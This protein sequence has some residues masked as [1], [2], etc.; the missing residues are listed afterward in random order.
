MKE[1]AELDHL[2]ETFDFL[3]DWTDRYR[4]LIE[5]AGKLPPF[6]EEARVAEN[7]V[8]GCMS[9][10]WLTARQDGEDPCVLHFRADSDAQIVKGLIAVLLLLYSGLTREEIRS[11]DAVEVFARL[12]LDQHLSVGRRNGLESMVKR[13][14]SLAAE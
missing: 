13:I 7:K 2:I 10:V 6:P 3:E 1:N 5:L 14:R 11:I 9:Q 4:H 8:E 12:G